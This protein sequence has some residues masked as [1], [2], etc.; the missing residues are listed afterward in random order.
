MFGHE[1]VS[2]ICANYLYEYIIVNDDFSIEG[3]SSSLDTYCD[4][5]LLLDAKVD[6][7]TLVP[8][9]VGMEGALEDLFKGKEKM[10]LIPLVFKEPEHYVNIRVHLSEDEK[11]C[12]VLFENITETTLA[13]QN[14]R[15]VHNEN[16]LLLE[17][18]AGKNRRLEQF[19][20]EMQRLVEEEVAKNME[21]QQ[22]IEIQSRHVQMG[23]MIGMITHQ[24]KQPLSAIQAT[25]ML[26][27][28][29]YELGTLTQA[30][31]S[32]KMDALLNQATH[33]N[34]TVSDFQTFFT[35]SKSKSHF[36]VKE[37]I[38]SVL[39]L[40]EMEYSLQNIAV[41]VEGE[42]DVLVYGYANEYNQVILALLQ[43][44]KDAFVENPHEHM[45]IRLSISQKGEVSWVEV[46]D[47]AGG[48]PEE[49]IDTL[50][51][52]YVST[53]KDGS[54]LGLHIAKTV[55]EDNMQGVLRV[56]NNEDGAVFTIVV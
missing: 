41:V 56:K 8:E 53:K 48:I 31:F 5:A 19:N 12:I 1:I 54:G 21:K 44:A 26:L 28:I 45:Q 7:F 38:L 10:L 47:N 23:E 6:L 24:W 50:F 11:H 32:E 36:N 15:Q 43:N 30:V 51:T 2:A 42:D 4:K 49:I 14:A 55:I 34:Q 46:R 40:V 37:T 22:T 25:G 13:Q 16:V 9:F 35:P 52:Q 17:E 27:K 39:S 29:K 20:Q 18:I 3:Y 33:M